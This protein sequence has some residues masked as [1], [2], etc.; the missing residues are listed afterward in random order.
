MAEAST[1]DSDGDASMQNNPVRRASI[2]HMSDDEESDERDESDKQD[3]VADNFG[4]A[5]GNSGGG[6]AA[7]GSSSDQV[8]GATHADFYRDQ[9][10]DQDAEAD[11]NE[12]ER[13]ERIEANHEANLR[14][15]SGHLTNDADDDARS[16][17][18]LSDNNSAG[19]VPTYD[20]YD[21]AILRNGEV[22]VPCL[23]AQD[24]L[25]KCIDRYGPIDMTPKRAMRINIPVDFFRRDAEF[26]RQWQLPKGCESRCRAS[27]ALVSLLFAGMQMGFPSG[28]HEE[29]VRQQAVS[30]DADQQSG[31]GQ[32]STAGKAPK[33]KPFTHAKRYTYAPHDD[34]TDSW[35]MFQIALEDI[36]NEEKTEIICLGVW[37]FIFDEM[38]STSALVRRVIENTHSLKTA[39]QVSAASAVSRN[40]DATAE[41]DRHG[42]AGFGFQQIR[43]NFEG[44][45]GL[46]YENVSTMEDWK[47][48]LDL[49]S[50]A[51]SG[52]PGRPCVADLAKHINCAAGR[53]RLE[54]DSKTGCG[55]KH[56]MAP[57]FVFNAKRQASLEF[58]MVNLDGSHM[59][60]CKHQVDPDQYWTAEG[61]FQLPDMNI[62]CFWICTS[63]EK[64]TPFDLPLT[65]PLQGTTTPGE[66]LMKLFLEQEQRQKNIEMGHPERRIR[67]SDLKIDQNAQ[68]RIRS[69]ATC[70]DEHQRRQDQLLRNTLLSYDLMTPANNAALSEGSVEYNGS[71]CGDEANYTIK[72]TAMTKR[73]AA[74][75]DRIYTKVIQPW[76]SRTE[77]ELIEMARPLQEEEVPEDDPEWDAYWAKRAEFNERF[78]NVKRDVTQYHLRLLRTC[79]LSTKD[80]ATLPSGYKVCVLLDHCFLVYDLSDV[81]SP[82]CA[83]HVQGSRGWRT[84]PRRLRKHC[85]QRRQAWHRAAAHVQGPSGVGRPAGVAAQRVCRLLQDRGS[86]PQNNGKGS[87]SSGSPPCSRAHRIR[88]QPIGR[89]ISSHF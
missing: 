34:E 37:L 16:S 76:V 15:R 1:N 14:L 83:G 53:R 12:C 86:G 81:P 56:P 18:G 70:R 58:G 57:E 80:A 38:H 39:K 9:L 79:F 59:N 35:P 48:V 23:L 5:E 21:E 26:F 17:A 61:N 2:I 20:G 65:R 74:E 60:V 30:D 63:V 89:G 4:E 46:Q 22:A 32:G 28:K 27:A 11:A 10:R 50:G 40:K 71:A 31:S 68:N 67:L 43:D 77:T 62:P 54:G 82:L 25:W 73:V 8:P 36:Y 66:H 55:G 3:E 13:L 33:V 7:A 52:H 6:G 64:K 87:P 75:S 45:V 69:L 19:D 47:R 51:T 42:K 72:T 78:Y 84:G 85:V 49:H 29:T 88:L 41:A 44:T 24:D